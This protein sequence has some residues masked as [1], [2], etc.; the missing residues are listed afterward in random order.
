MDDVVRAVRVLRVVVRAAVRWVLRAAMAA[1]RLLERLSRL[2]Q[3]LA[4]RPRLLVALVVLAAVAGP[5][6]LLVASAALGS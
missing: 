5:F 4:P 3:A 1:R 2:T 6:P